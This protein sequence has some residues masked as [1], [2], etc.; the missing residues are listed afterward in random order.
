M[1]LSFDTLKEATIGLSFGVDKESTMQ[2]KPFEPSAEI[3]PSDLAATCFRKTCLLL[4]SFFFFLPHNLSALQCL[5]TCPD[6]SYRVKALPCWS[7]QASLSLSTKAIH[8]DAGSCA[9]ICLISTMLRSSPSENR[10]VLSEPEIASVRISSESVAAIRLPPRSPGLILNRSTGFDA[11]NRSD[12]IRHSSNLSSYSES[13]MPL[14]TCTGDMHS[15]DSVG[16]S[17]LDGLSLRKLFREC[18]RM[19][20]SMPTEAIFDFFP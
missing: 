20:E 17:L 6:V 16:F 15:G 19:S 13:A 1:R 2:T 14:R 10:T 18:T 4:L 11:G 12:G 9:D 5:E 3:R 7:I 8:F